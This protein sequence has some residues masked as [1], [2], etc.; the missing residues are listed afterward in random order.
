MPGRESWFRDP[1]HAFIVAGYD[2]QI[3]LAQAVDLQ[4]RENEISA[5][6]HVGRHIKIS[7]GK[8]GADPVCGFVVPHGEAVGVYRRALGGEGRQDLEG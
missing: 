7:V 3:T 1:D 8:G 2:Q 5:A 6:K 4:I